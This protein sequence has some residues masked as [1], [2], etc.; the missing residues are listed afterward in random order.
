M[1]V[2]VPKNFSESNHF[3]VWTKDSRMLSPF[4]CLKSCPAS[5]VLITK[6]DC[7]LIISTPEDVFAS[8]VVL[9]KESG[10]NKPAQIM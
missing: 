7:R 2:N 5:D 9:R 6:H 4:K 3:I 1:R 10:M 8:T